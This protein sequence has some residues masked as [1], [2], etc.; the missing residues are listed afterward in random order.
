MIGN[1]KKL[2]SNARPGGQSEIIAFM[3]RKRGEI[4]SSAGL[5]FMAISLN[6]RI[7]E[8]NHE[9][10]WISDVIKAGH[11]A[12]SVAMFGTREVAVDKEGV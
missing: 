8:F 9:R 10:C 11:E 5:V 4:I 6:G 3:K 2:K 12:D 1:S 7:T